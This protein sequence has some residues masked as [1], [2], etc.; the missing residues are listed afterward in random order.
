MLYSTAPGSVTQNDLASL[1]FDAP[2]GITGRVD[3]NID[4]NSRFSPG[5]RFH[6]F[7]PPSSSLTVVPRV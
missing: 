4:A 7:S 5:S 2:M 1:I 3:G 6:Y